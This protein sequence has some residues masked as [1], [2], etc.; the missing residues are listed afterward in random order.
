MASSRSMCPVPPPSGCWD[1]FCSVVDNFGDIGVCW[2][3][4]R[5]LAA[6]HGI[7]VRLW[8]DDLHSARRLMPSLDIGH[9]AQW[10]D[11][12]EVRRWEATFPAVEPGQV[13]LAA[14]ACRLPEVFVEAMAR[15]SPRPV[16]INLEYLSAED[17]V[18]DCHALPSPHPRLPL[19]EHFFFPG[20]EPQT[21]GV[22]READYA[23]RHAAFPVN[24]FRSALGLPPPAPDELCIS[25]F[26]YENAGLAGLL[27]AWRHASRPVT[28]LVPEGRVVASLAP[29][30]GAGRLE[31]GDRLQRGA[32]TVQVLPFVEQR[33]YDE[34]LWACDLNFVRG[35]DSFVRA[36]WAARPFVWHI[37]P[38]EEDAHVVKLDAFVERFGAGLDGGSRRALADFWHAWNRGQGAA[39]AWPAFEAALPA[40]AEHGERWVERLEAA[41]ELASKLVQ[42]CELKIE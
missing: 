22:L 31:V 1:L 8:V 5:Q 11:G 9:A 25:L 12:V 36:Q 10:V 13:V 27:D 7:S 28:C 6:E 4:A 18:A 24:G 32:L 42:F 14:F 26:S 35:E 2:R 15:R 33:R 23:A 16:W 38:Q 17:W 39:E 40:L 3:L 30:L 29:A 41:G 19:V 34:L 20:F 21:G 37:Y